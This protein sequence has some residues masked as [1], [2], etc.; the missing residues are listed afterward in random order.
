MEVMKALY[1][2]PIVSSLPPWDAHLV[3]HIC[4]ISSMSLSSRYLVLTCSIA[5]RTSYSFHPPGRPTY[6]R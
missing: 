3:C 6:L 4:S 5:I 1:A 2:K